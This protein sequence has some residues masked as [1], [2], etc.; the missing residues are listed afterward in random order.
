MKKDNSHN[1]AIIK[2]SNTEQDSLTLSKMASIDTAYSVVLF[3]V[4]TLTT[5]SINIDNIENIITATK[6]YNSAS[7]EGIRI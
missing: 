1:I 5:D 4:A 6:G 3:F 7:F 2:Q